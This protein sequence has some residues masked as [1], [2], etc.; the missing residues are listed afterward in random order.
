MSE[1]VFPDGYDEA[2]AQGLLRDH[3]AK[4]QAFCPDCGSAVSVK[5]AGKFETRIPHYYIK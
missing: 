1:G 3:L 5:D 4:G 2:T